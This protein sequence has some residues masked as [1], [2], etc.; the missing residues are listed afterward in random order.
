MGGGDAYIR[1]AYNQ[2]FAFFGYKYVDEPT[3]GKAGGK[4]KAAVYSIMSK[5]KH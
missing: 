2:M 1:Q 4:L 3:T 5:G